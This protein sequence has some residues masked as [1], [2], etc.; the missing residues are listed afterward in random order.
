MNGFTWQPRSL[1]AE[2]KANLN[3]RPFR[4]A[5]FFI[6]AAGI[7]L[8][9]ALAELSSASNATR[10]MRQLTSEGYST[11]KITQPEPDQTFPA[12][13]CV[14]FDGQQGVV[15]AGAIGPP[16]TVQTSSDP[17]N[18]FVEAPAYGDVTRVLSSQPDPIT[19]PGVIISNEL[20]GELGVTVGSYLNLNSFVTPVAS[21]ADLSKKDSLLGRVALNPQTASL[22]TQ[23]QA[24]YIQ[25]RTAVLG[26]GAAAVQAVYAAYPTLQYSYLIPH[27]ST[28]NNPSAQWHNRQSRYIWVA[29]GATLAITAIFLL[30]RRRHEL[31]VYQI[32][33]SLR[34]Q[35]A[36]LA[37]AETQIVTWAAAIAA[38]AWV[39]V[40]ARYTHN[41]FNAYHIAITATERTALLAASLQP[42]GL[43]PLLKRDL[44]RTLRERAS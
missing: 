33:G 43:I 1:L 39:A 41:T 36:L 29:A 31:A 26:Q 11:I 35:T 8:L 16:T 24:C 23:I 20:A 42:L 18:T 12:R 15:A 37:L 27:G 13:G 22:S 2:V 34:T 38:I 25:F 32:T 21:V 7:C 30:T 19:R 9:P 4:A 44:T 28:T 10:A 40:V 14:S 17:G 3:V 6:V 5:A